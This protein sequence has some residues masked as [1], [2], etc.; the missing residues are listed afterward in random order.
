M[1][2]PCNQPGCPE[3]LTE[4]GYCK[5]HEPEK[6]NTAQSNRYAETQKDNPLWQ[7]AREVRNSERYRK[8]RTWFKARYP[9]CCDPLDRHGTK[10]VTATDLHHII[11]LAQRP[12]LATT[13]TNC[14]PLCSHCH[15]AIEA[16]E[17]EGTPT[18]CLFKR[19]QQHDDG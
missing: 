1:F 8:F 7:A 15:R 6:D 11:G 3:L 18:Q 12:D 10:P 4:P 5:Q 13:E 2:F 14:A 16:M 19:G 17:R 9:L